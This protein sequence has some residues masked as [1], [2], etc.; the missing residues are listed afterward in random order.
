MTLTFDL[1]T[2]AQII[3]AFVST[4]RG[5]RAALLKEALRLYVANGEVQSQEEE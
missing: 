4:P 2:D 1:N 3:D 5:K